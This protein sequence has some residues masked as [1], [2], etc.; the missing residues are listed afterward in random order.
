MENSKRCSG[1]QGHDGSRKGLTDWNTAR[2]TT[3]SVAFRVIGVLEDERIGRTPIWGP[4]PLTTE[5]ENILR[6][7]S[8]GVASKDEYL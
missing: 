5:E 4:C 1:T 2:Q 6:E 8:A 3:Q 7:L